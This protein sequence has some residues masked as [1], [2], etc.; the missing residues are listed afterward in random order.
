MNI[1]QLQQVAEAANGPHKDGDWLEFI[2]TFNPAVVL[3]LLQALRDAK[4][5]GLRRAVS[6]VASEPELPGEM[7]WEMFRAMKDACDLKPVA[8]E[9]CRGIVRATKQNILER[10]TTVQRTAGGRDE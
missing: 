7:P 5:E 6:I 4:A 1:D 3:Q 10:L 2:A 9:F 8:E